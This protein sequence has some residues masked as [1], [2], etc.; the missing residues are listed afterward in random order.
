MIQSKMK[1]QYFTD[2]PGQST[3][4][5]PL[6]FGKNDLLGVRVQNGKVGTGRRV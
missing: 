4:L 6:S 3:G 2:I 5:Y 1:V